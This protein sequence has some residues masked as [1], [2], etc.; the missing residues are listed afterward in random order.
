MKRLGTALPMVGT[1]LCAIMAMTGS[2]PAIAEPVT[3]TAN[4][5]AVIIQP[6]TAQNSADLDFGTIIPGTSNSTVAVAW[7]DARTCGAALTCS[8]TITAPKWLVTGSG[9]RTLIWT[10][11]ASTTVS[12]GSDTMTVDILNLGSTGTIPASGSMTIAIGAV[13][14]VDANQPAGNYSGTFNV[15]FS[16]Y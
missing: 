8:G 15:D 5:R 7:N 6:I 1:A 9:G 13:L 3:T 14:H 10:G 11:A 16:Y 12:S 2:A 4:A